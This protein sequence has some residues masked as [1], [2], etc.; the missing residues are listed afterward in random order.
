MISE[1]ARIQVR[2]SDESRLDFQAGLGEPLGLYRFVFDTLPQE[3]RIAK[4]PVLVPRLDLDV[5]WRFL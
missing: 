4:V 1:L 5:T 3:T 2:L